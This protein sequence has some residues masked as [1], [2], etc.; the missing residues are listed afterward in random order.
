MLKLVL[1]FDSNDGVQT[2]AAQKVGPKCC[3]LFLSCLR[4]QVVFSG[5]H[6]TPQRKLA[7]HGA[8]YNKVGNAV[9][10]L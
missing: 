3:S 6:L 8:V 9:G 10:W 7:P 5:C 2:L 4:V 1:W